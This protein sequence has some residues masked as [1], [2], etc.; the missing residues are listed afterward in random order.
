MKACVID[1][2]NH[3]IKSSTLARRVLVHSAAAVIASGGLAACCLQTHGGENQTKR[4]AWRSWCMWCF[5]SSW[6]HASS[7]KEIY[8]Y[9][10]SP[11]LQCHFQWKGGGARW[12]HCST[13]PASLS[14]NSGSIQ[15]LQFAHSSSG[16]MWVSGRWSPHRTLHNKRDYSYQKKYRKVFPGLCGWYFPNISSIYF[17]VAMNHALLWSLPVPP[18]ISSEML[19]L[20]HHYLLMFI[21]TVRV[22]SSLISQTHLLQHWHDS[23][24]A[25]NRKEMDPK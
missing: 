5:F 6:Q 8:R 23:R 15:L 25:V 12:I 1:S 18:C 16:R 7:L 22:I 17:G 20:N 2:D 4:E 24:S 14:P 11:V 10:P 13:C 21:S 9:H 19:I 3:R